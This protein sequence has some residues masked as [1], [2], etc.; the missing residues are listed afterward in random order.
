MI[1]PQGFLN[2][3]KAERNWPVYRIMTLSR[4]FDMF[5]QR[6]NV[7]VKPFKW[8][9]PF[10][11]FIA[12]LKGKLPTGELVEFA[13]RYDFYGQCWTITGGTDAMWRIYSG[14]KKSVRIKVR[15][16]RLYEQLYSTAIGPAFIGKVRYLR[17]V[18]LREWIKR[19]VRRADRPDITLLAK[20]FL[21]KRPAFAHENEVRLLYCST[22]NDAHGLLYRHRFDCRVIEEIEIDP[23]LTPQEA[24]TVMAEIKVRTGYGGRMIQSPLYRPPE[25]FVLPLNAAY[26]SL[27]RSFDRVSYSG[28]F[29]TV[30]HDERSVPQLVFPHVHMLNR[31]RTS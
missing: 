24:K 13:P 1:D 2:L 22:R 3:P 21:V 28:E 23:R 29:R 19:L 20:T 18:Q 17:E 10:E 11:N 25:D 4:L 7:L 27:P 16:A 14:D 15:I 8:D 26:A 9:D 31:E 6:A 12:H 30:R 5:D